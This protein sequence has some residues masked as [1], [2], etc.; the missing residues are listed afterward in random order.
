[1][2]IGI[3]AGSFDLF[4]AG[5]VLMMKEAKKYCDHLLVL[6]QNDPSTDREDK[7]RPVQS[8]PERQ[9]QVSSCKYVDEVMVYNNES[10]L[11]E[12]LI[13]ID[14][15][16]RIIGADWQGKAFTGHD[17]PGHVDKCIF[18][19]R[20]HNYSSSYLRSRVYGAESDKLNKSLD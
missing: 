13:S 15:D 7:N 10:E 18:N 20:D 5:H 16:V 2:K 14:Y 19:R 1:M 3:T 17:I 4:H 12:I 9:I 6:L 8:L 11:F